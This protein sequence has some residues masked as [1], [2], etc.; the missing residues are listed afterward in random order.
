[1]EKAAQ[2]P[3]IEITPDMIEAGKRALIE[4]SEGVSYFDQGAVDIFTA[5]FSR[6]KSAQSPL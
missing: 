1:M 3:E 5:M 2:T 4:W 6:Y